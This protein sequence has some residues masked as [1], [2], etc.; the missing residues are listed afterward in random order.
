MWCR[1]GRRRQPT[2]GRLSGGRRRQPRTHNLDTITEGYQRPESMGD[3]AD[4]A[5]GKLPYPDL[6]PDERRWTL[7]HSAT[8]VNNERRNSRS[9]HF[10]ANVGVLLYQPTYIKEVLVVPVDRV[11]PEAGT[12]REGWMA[13]EDRR[14]RHA[15]SQTGHSG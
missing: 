1:K 13:A 8:A 3:E 2:A 7:E 11:W 5:G 12:H 4:Q 15:P 6:T 14:C 9:G 10:G